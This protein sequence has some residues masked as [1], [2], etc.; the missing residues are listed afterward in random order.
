MGIPAQRWGIPHTAFVR[1]SISQLPDPYTRLHIIPDAPY[2]TT[3]DFR[4]II[5]TRTFPPPS[6]LHPSALLTFFFE[7]TT[8]SGAHFNSFLRTALTRDGQD[9]KTWVGIDVGR[10]GRRRDAQGLADFR[11]LTFGLLSCFTLLT[12]LFPFFCPDPQ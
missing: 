12:I 10:T 8:Q 11:T 2:N 1:R 5:E 6:R 7:R 9:S 4:T 3:D